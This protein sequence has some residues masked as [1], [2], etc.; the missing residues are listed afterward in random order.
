[1]R[2]KIRPQPISRG[3]NKFLLLVLSIFLTSHIAYAD[4]SSFIFST[5][6]QTIIPNVLSGPIT[7]QAQNNLAAEEAVTETIGLTFKST[8]LTGEFLG[9]TGKAVSKTMAKG[10]AN[11]T[12]Y[13][14]DTNA[15]TYT[16]TVT[17]IGRT[18][19]KNFSVTQQI[20]ISLTLPAKISLPKTATLP[21]IQQKITRIS[22]PKIPPAYIQISKA[23]ISTTQSQAKDTNSSTT[24]LAT[25]YEG[26]S[27]SSIF[28][29]IFD[30]PPR[31]WGWL[32]SIFR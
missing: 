16:L 25:I 15:G 1:M 30:W 22:S 2:P 18:S 14:R 3:N 8:S 7:I 27:K 28:D 19:R 24:N 4:V 20:V 10:T 31:F 23:E 13:Y 21:V 9:S 32:K 26:K 6:P 12:F 29:V 17:A 5:D 11:R